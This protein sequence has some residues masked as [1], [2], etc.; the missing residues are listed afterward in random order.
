M[1][2]VDGSRHD[3]RDKDN[4]ALKALREAVR[5][6]FTEGVNTNCASRCVFIRETVTS[7]FLCAHAFYLILDY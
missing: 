1:E 3:V 6:E 7:S 4:A 2:H 5:V